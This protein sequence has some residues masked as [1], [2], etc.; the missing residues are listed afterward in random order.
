MR[1]CLCRRK[2]GRGRGSKKH[3][4]VVTHG[5]QWFMGYVINEWYLGESIIF[6]VTAFKMS[7][8]DLKAILDR[9]NV[10]SKIFCSSLTKV[11]S[12]VVIVPAKQD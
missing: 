1:V 12:K 3:R 5:P 11:S 2:G 9:R 7:I 4:N 10:F 6:P 8:L